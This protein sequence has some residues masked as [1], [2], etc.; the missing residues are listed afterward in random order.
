MNSCDLFYYCLP[1]NFSFFAAFQPSGGPTTPKRARSCRPRSSLEKKVGLGF[2]VT[3]L[4]S[5]RNRSPC[6]KDAELLHIQHDLLAEQG[7]EVNGAA[8]IFLVAILSRVLLW[9][10]LGAVPDAGLGSS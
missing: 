6:Q 10:C 2:I 9:V 4:N 7:G 3:D 8:W 1:S 5:S